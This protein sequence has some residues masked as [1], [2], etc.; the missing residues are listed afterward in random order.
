MT[1][2][3]TTATLFSIVLGI[4]LGWDDAFKI[5]RG[6]RIYKSGK[7]I[8]AVIVFVVLLINSLLVH[9][10][11]QAGDI[12]T[13]EGLF[14]GIMIVVS[15]NLLGV[16]SLAIATH[17]GTYWFTHDLVI[18]LGTNKP[19]NYVSFGTG[20][21]DTALSDSAFHVFGEKYAGIVQI[22]LKVVVFASFMYFTIV[23]M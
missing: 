17:F 8:Q 14:K 1:Y 21:P 20:N 7:D 2:T 9:L 5:N 22:I 11:L 16:L 23:R 13:Y 15:H 10:F 4:L 6:Y 12:S 19:W 18:N 3:L